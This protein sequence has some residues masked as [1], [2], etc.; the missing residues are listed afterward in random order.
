[1][2]ISVYESEALSSFRTMNLKQEKSISLS[3]LLSFSL[4]PSSFSHP[5]SVFSSYRDKMETIEMGPDRNG[6]DG[7]GVSWSDLTL[8]ATSECY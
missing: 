3:L 2:V 7:D 1:M 8:A 6:D 5:L 4:P